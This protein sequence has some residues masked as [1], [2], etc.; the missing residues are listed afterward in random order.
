MSSSYFCLT[1]LLLVSAH[2][3]AG[4]LDRSFLPTS[5]GEGTAT[6][7]GQPATTASPDADEY[8]PGDVDLDPAPASVDQLIFEQNLHDA[9]VTLKP[10][11]PVPV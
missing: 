11:K 7:P 5:A 6:T 4:V 1:L 9:V 2:M 3:A 8:I 10:L